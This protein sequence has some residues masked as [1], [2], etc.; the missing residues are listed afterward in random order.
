VKH[1]SHIDQVLH[2]L[3]LIDIS[4]NPI[5]H[6]RVDIRLKFCLEHL[7][8]DLSPPKF[9]RQIVRHKQPFAGI[10]DK[11]LPYRCAQI[12]GAKHFAAS[13]MEKSRDRSEHFTL[14]PFATAWS[15]QEEISYIAIHTGEC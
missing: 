7:C 12:E 9:N 13:T 14:S 3:G 1:P 10:L 6:Q 15:A 5:K 11:F 2:E 8:F 4:G